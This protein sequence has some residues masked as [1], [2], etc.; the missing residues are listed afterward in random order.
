MFLEED[1]DLEEELHET[2][3]H[4]LDEF[5]AYLH[6]TQKLK[7]NTVNQHVGRM[8]FFSD[9]YLLY[10]GSS[11]EE[12]DADH[13]INFLGDFYIRKVF[14][15]TESDVGPYLTTF[16]RF[17]K[18]LFEKEKLSKL[19][20]DEINMVCKQKDYF[21][22]R[23]ETYFATD[24]L[25]SWHFSN[26]LDEYLEEMESAYQFDENHTLDIDAN[27]V[28]LLNE[29]TFDNPIAV[30]AFSAFIEKIRQEKSVKLTSTKQYITRKF[31]MELDQSQNLNLF[32]K[33]TL[34]QEDIGLFHFFYVAGSHLKLLRITGNKLE[35]TKLLNVY[36]QLTEKE[37]F[38]LLIDVLWNQ[39]SWKDVQP[40]TAGGRIEISQANRSHFA[41]T[42][43]EFPV[44]EEVKLRES[45]IGARLTNQM[46]SGVTD[47]F[48][49]YI[50]PILEYFDLFELK[51]WFSEGDKP[52]YMG[53][54]S[55]KINSFGIFICNQL[56]KMSDELPYDVPLDPMTDLLMQLGSMAA[57]IIKEKKVGR[58]DPCPCGSGKKYKRCCM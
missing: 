4:T 35:P 50:M 41:E 13:I 37:Q 38:V 23:F 25:E 21:K 49:K 14:N 48:L 30:K 5:Y 52:Y 6:D 22:H 18:F 58:N 45:Q 56:K 28:H 9:S 29:R 46:F 2:L 27:F 26:D 11:I 43:A 54:D 17:A 53:I 19:E 10:D 42:L 7:E 33:P 12:F 51:L 20:F 36:Q 57:P 47:H 55:I 24:D 34:N 31:W 1:E 16:K 44:D 8:R 3:R 39:L 15:S 32:T 40:S